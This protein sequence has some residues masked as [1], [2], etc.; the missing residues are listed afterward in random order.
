MFFRLFWIHLASFFRIHFGELPTALHLHKQIH[1]KPPVRFSRAWNRAIWLD[2]SVKIL[3]IHHSVFSRWG[4]PF[5]AEREVYTWF[6]RKNN[7]RLYIWYLRIYL[8]YIWT[9]VKCFFQTFCLGR[10]YSAGK[11]FTGKINPD[12]ILPVKLKFYRQNK[13]S[14]YSTGKN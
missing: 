11:N 10:V 7:I 14:F 4:E 1:E 6:K 3:D 12:F 2:G 8:V 5:P 13:S 9:K